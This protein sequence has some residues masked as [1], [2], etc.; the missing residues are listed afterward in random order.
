MSIH[1]I[2]ERPTVPEPS[3]RPEPPVPT[4]KDAAD[5][6][7]RRIETLQKSREFEELAHRAEQQGLEVRLHPVADTD[8]VSIQFVD[9]ASGQVV[10]EFPNERL[11]EALAAMRAQAL[12][13]IDRQV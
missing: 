3:L 7:V 2:P 4:H 13:Q 11:V 9:P 8:V 12:S 10:H 6:A 5:T 1:R